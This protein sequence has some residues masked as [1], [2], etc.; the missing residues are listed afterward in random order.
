MIFF[1]RK[2]RLV[3]FLIPSFLM[4]GTA[5]DSCENFLRILRLVHLVKNSSVGKMGLLSFSP[6]AKNLVDREKNKF[7][8]WHVLGLCESLLLIYN[9]QLCIKNEFIAYNAT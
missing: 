9:I 8:E 3:P 1:L 2:L 5:L 4:N 7:G 6:A